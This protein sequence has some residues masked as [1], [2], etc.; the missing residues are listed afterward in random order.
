MKQRLIISLLSGLLLLTVSCGKT[1]NGTASKSAGAASRDQ[2]ATTRKE[3]IAQNVLAV[4][5]AAHHEFETKMMFAPTEPIPASLY[6]MAS[7]YS[8]SRRIVAFLTCDEVVIE[9]QSIAVSAND[10]REAFDFRFSK[11]PRPLGN[12][13]IDFIEVARSN[14]KPM[15]LA[16]LFLTVE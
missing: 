10:K 15:L 12:Y 3:I 9:E 14:G 6:L 7:P 16:R 4:Q 13:R 2:V 1:P 8:E 11:T 5:L